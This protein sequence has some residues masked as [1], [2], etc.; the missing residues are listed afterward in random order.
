[1]YCS[2]P[3]IW[4]IFRSVSLSKIERIFALTILNNIINKKCDLWNNWSKQIRIWNENIDGPYS[5]FIMKF[6]NLVFVNIKNSFVNFSQQS[7]MIET[8]ILIYDI[9]SDIDIMN[10]VHVVQ[11]CLNYQQQ[12]TIFK[13]IIENDIKQMNA[14]NLGNGCP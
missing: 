2:A 14:L 13:W 6:K 4:W 8:K 5:E 12:T 9:G 10:V 1:M 3:C 7:K 11:K